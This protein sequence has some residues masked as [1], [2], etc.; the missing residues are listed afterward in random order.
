MPPRG[1]S[2][3]NI[4]ESRAIKLT[5]ARYFTP[6]GRSIQAQ[7]IYPDIRVDQGN[8][9]WDREDNALSE[10][11]LAGHL[12]NGTLN[13]GTAGPELLGLRETL[14]DIE[15]LQLAHAVSLLQGS[16][17]LQQLK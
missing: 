8:I 3:I 17:L 14:S 1:P 15:D 6:S 7:G 10:A 2:V 11:S 13:S 12:N 9:N 16:A 5:I 4:D